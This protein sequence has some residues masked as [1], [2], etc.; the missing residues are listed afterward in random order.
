MLADPGILRQVTFLQ[1][2]SNRVY[3]SLYVPETTDGVAVLI[4][5]SW[6][7]EVALAVDASHRLAW[8]LA[9]QGVACTLYHPPG[10]LDSTGDPSDVSVDDLVAAAV[11]SSVLLRE[12]CRDG[13]LRLVGIGLG[14]SVA[15]LAAA[16]LGAHSLVLVEPEVDPAAFFQGLRRAGARAS[17]R[18]GDRDAPFGH[19]VPRALP[20]RELTTRVAGALA[21]LQGRVTAFRFASS[22]PTPLPPGIETIDLPGGRTGRRWARRFVEPVASFLVE[23][24][25]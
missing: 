21:A 4:C 23:G 18:Q 11:D 7:A 9:E 8:T 3:A 2:G 14:A 5:P 10:H 13:E 1:S 12:H 24:A 22:S 19:A 20:G 17:L 6:G 15:A 16:R 25:A